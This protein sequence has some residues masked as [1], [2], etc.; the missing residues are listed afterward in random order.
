MGPFVQENGHG[1][2][3]SDKNRVKTYIFDC[4]V[5]PG[6][7]QHASLSYSQIVT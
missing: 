4:F 3:S 7:I 6:P 2:D 1:N 5:F